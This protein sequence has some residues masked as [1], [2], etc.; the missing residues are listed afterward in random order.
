[1]CEFLESKRCPYHTLLKPINISEHQL[2]HLP[3]PSHRTATGEL[4]QVLTPSC[5]RPNG[6]INTE[7]KATTGRED[8]A[9]YFWIGNEPCFWSIR[10]E[11]NPLRQWYGKHGHLPMGTERSVGFKHLSP[12]IAGSSQHPLRFPPWSGPWWDSFSFL[13]SSWLASRYYR[14]KP[15]SP[16]LAFRTLQEAASCYPFGPGSQPICASHLPPSA[17]HTSRPWLT[18]QPV[19]PFHTHP[20]RKWW[21]LVKGYL[22]C[23]CSHD[24]RSEWITP[25]SGQL[26]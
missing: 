7:T 16:R 14:C 2:I 11:E 20:W 17:S 10:S 25:Y 12:G 21:D 3:R 6:R 1:M 8:C 19:A 13:W 15:T 22:L 26:F 24:T 5:A 18:A 23:E 4:M 9:L